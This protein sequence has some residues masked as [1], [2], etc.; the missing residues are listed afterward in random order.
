MTTTEVYKVLS[1]KMDAQHEYT[2][3]LLSNI[4]EQTL[5]T[6]GRVSAVEGRI[7]DI[8]KGES[9]H[10][11]NCPNIKRIETLEDENQEVRIIKKYPKLALGIFVV[12]VGIFLVSGWFGY[13]RLRA[14]QDTIQ[15][16][17]HI[18]L[19]SEQSLLKNNEPSDAP[20][21]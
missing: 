17:Q 21:H 2:S 18:I 3:K 19:N 16:R 9:S 13:Q 15:A 4:Y 8:E 12:F 11:I 14:E 10:I 5:R 20:H 7:I 1:E 6:N